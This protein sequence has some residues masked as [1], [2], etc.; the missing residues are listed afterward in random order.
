MAGGGLVTGG[1]WGSLEPLPP[2]LPQAVNNRAAPMRPP[3]RNVPCFIVMFPLWWYQRP[4]RRTGAMIAAP[5][6]R[7]CD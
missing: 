4:K 7:V 3:W 1:C 6:A 2:P 5:S